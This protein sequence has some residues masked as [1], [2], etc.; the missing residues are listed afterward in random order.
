MLSLFKIRTLLT[1]LGFVL[2]AL[3]I[4][5][6]GPYFGFG[7]YRPLESRAASR[8]IVIALV[9]VGMVVVED[10]EASARQRA[11]DNLIAAVVKQSEADRPSRAP[12]RSNC[13]SGSKRRLRTLKQKRRGGRISTTCRGTSSSARPGSGK[14]TALVNSGLK[15]PSR[16]AIGQGGAARR[17]RHAQLRLVVHR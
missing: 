11:S 12:R 10:A 8:I 7:T 14:T 9:I 1:G 16:A 6:A 17:R 2:L 3:F 5:F 13:A 4:W 15:F